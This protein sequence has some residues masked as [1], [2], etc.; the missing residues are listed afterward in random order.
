[1]T[2]ADGGK[3]QKR[4]ERSGQMKLR[5]RR[6]GEGRREGREKERTSGLQVREG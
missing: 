6:E 4:K 5:E 1:V 3:E 2:S